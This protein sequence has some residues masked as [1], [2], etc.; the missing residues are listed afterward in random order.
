MAYCPSWT[1][2]QEKRGDSR[3]KNP[4]EQPH[5]CREKAVE[6]AAEG[7]DNSGEQGPR[8]RHD[9]SWN[10]GAPQ[11]PRQGDGKGELGAQVGGPA[12]ERL[13]R[14]QRTEDEDRRA[15]VPYEGRCEGT[16]PATAEGN[17]G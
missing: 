12:V 17:G 5:G 11:Q 13:E 7:Q 4:G 3:Q 1:S 2:P 9:A 16:S 6:D 8:E 10:A 14:D 15:A